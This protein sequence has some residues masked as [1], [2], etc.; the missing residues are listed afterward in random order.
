MGQYVWISYLSSEGVLMG[1][2]IACQALSSHWLSLSAASMPQ[3][4]RPWPLHKSIVLPVSSLSR[5]W[6]IYRSAILRLKIVFNAR[7]CL[8]SASPQNQACRVNVTEYW[9]TSA[10]GYA[11]PIVK[12]TTSFEVN[13]LPTY[14]LFHTPF[15]CINKNCAWFFRFA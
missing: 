4:I 7:H 15:P 11:W 12:N 13:R 14:I 9:I 1:A 8:T 10:V 6:W 2:F 3:W 5:A